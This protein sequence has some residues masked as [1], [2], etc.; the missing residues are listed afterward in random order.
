MTL[1]NAFGNLATEAKQDSAIAK[2][3]SVDNKLPA[4]N[5]GRLPAAILAALRDYAPGYSTGGTGT[6]EITADPDGALITRGSVLT[7]EGSSRVNFAN[8]S[9]AVSIGSGVFTNG[10]ATVTGSGFS[11][12]VIDKGDYIKLDADAESA[13][14]Q[15]ESIDSDTSITL[16]N[17]YAGTG[18]AGASSRAMVKPVTGT[19]GTIAVSSG[20]CTLASGTTINQTTSIERLIDYSPL[21]VNL[22]ITVSQRIANNDTYIEIRD[23]SATAKYFCRIRLSGTTNTAAICETGYNPTTAPS[24]AETESTTVTLPN[25]ATTAAARVFRIE[26]VLSATRYYCDNMLMAEH[27]KVGPHPNDP[28]L[29]KVSTVNA[30]SAPATSTTVTVD[31]LLAQNFN[32]LNVAP[33]S[34]NDR[35]VADSAPVDTF[36]GSAGALNADALIIDCAKYRCLFVQVSGTFSATVTFQASNFADFTGVLTNGA[37][38]AAGAIVTSTTGAGMW[39]LAPV[40]RY[41][42]FRA[43]AWTSGAAVVTVHATQQPPSRAVQITAYNGTQAV[44]ASVT[45]YPTAAASADALANPTV[46]KIDATTL[47]FNGTSWDRARNNVNTTT[48]DTGAKTASF[49]GATQTNFNAA[50]AFILINMG[51]VTGTT[52]TLTAQVQISPDGGTT[53]VNVPGAVTPSITASGTTLLTVYPGVTPAANA[54]VSYPLARTWRLN[55]TIGGTTPSF[56]I[57]NVQVSYIN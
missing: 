17:N 20:T 42:R 3:T 44:T 6:T 47:R 55:Y 5:L 2:L 56:T 39:V 15:V 48:G 18:G 40:G 25:G 43:T 9:I 13:W 12:R 14:A 38:S 41:I 23:P 34:G 27:R 24:A 46:T 51:T 53:W 50:G 37:T 29:L 7:D 8:S 57:T 4:Q 28:M 19:G 54:A 35:M 49:A 32:A 36:T 21:G 30:G 45:G 31:H 26:S 52:P 11:T 1:Q 10:S 33:S 22:G 16:V